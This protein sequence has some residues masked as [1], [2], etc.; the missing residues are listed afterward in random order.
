VAERCRPEPRRRARHA[1]DCPVAKVT[2]Y[3]VLS[4]N[5]GSVGKAFYCV[6]RLSKSVSPFLQNHERVRASR[7]WAVVGHLDARVATLLIGLFGQIVAASPF[8][9]VKHFSDLVSTIN[10]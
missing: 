6:A 3:R 4:A 9:F 2:C 7:P 10:L 1:E 5:P 8:R